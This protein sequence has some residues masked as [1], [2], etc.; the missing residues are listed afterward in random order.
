MQRIGDGVR[1]AHNAALAD[2]DGLAGLRHVGCAGPDCLAAS[3][4]TSRTARTSATRRTPANAS[5]R[6]R[7]PDP[8]RPPKARDHRIEHLFHSRR[9]DCGRNFGHSHG[10]LWYFSTRTPADGPNQLDTVLCASG[11]NSPV[12]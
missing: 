12:R 5:A 11:R 10:A 3:P 4:G 7:S 6:T 1:I 9:E 8:K 2:L